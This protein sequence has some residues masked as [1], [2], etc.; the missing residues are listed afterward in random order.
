MV[1]SL[2]K[3]DVILLATTASVL[4]TETVDGM[5]LQI[6]DEAALVIKAIHGLSVRDA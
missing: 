6:G 2:V 4:A 5:V 1:M 3:H